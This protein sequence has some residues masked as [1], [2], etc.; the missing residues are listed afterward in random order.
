MI[1]M[2]KARCFVFALLAAVLGLG[3]LG[4]ARAEIEI[5][6]NQGTL[7]PLPLAV[8]NFTGAGPY[9]ADIAKVVSA[10]LERSGFFRPLDPAGF[11]PGGLDVN[12]QPRFADWK[13]ISAQ[14]LVNGHVALGRV[15]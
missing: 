13:A 6:I 10:N 14:A 11:A 3:G 12:V 5:Q 2:R 15:F 1:G 9:G 4:P 7:Q 8:P